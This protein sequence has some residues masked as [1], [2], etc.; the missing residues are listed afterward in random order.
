MGLL[1]VD[2]REGVRELTIERPARRNALSPE[3]LEA[4]I[5][6]LATPPSIRA[7]ILTGGAEFFSAGADLHA[8]SGTA[9]DIAFDDAVGRA[10]R[11]VQ[12]C[13]VPVVAAIEGPCIGAAFD[14][15]LSC[16]LRVAGERAFF[17]FPPLR[18]GILYNPA[19]IQRLHRLLP[20]SA[21]ARLLLAGDRMGAA[22][23]FG[24]GIA[25]HLAPAGCALERAREL[26]ERMAGFEPLALA[27]TRRLL[28]ELDDG[29]RD[30]SAFADVR[31]TL[32]DSPARREALARRRGTHGTA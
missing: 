25:T 2:D 24:E 15:A 22:E 23:A 20:R 11:S 9:A 31:A 3:L 29:A 17:E 27:S 19:A 26:A 16:D 8:L 5:E 6:A 13:A 4:L 30:L 32:L 28:R 21:L 10:V 12:S 18:L 7:A 1:R 14:L